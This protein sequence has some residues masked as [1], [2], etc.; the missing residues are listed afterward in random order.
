MGIPTCLPPSPVT[1]A[2]GGGC[3]V[4]EER[5]AEELPGLEGQ[6]D[7]EWEGV[8]IRVMPSP[9]RTRGRAYLTRCLG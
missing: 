1:S 7:R 9:W 2:Q 8:V 6:Q 5:E 3:P 4:E